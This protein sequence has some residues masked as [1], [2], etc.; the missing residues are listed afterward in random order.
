V[1]SLTGRAERAVLGAMISD[2]GLVGRLEYLQAGDFADWRHRAVFTAI[3]LAAGEPGMTADRWHSAITAHTSPQVPAQLINNLPGACPVVAHGVAYG[4]LVVE[5]SVH[6]QLAG[7]GR[8]LASRGEELAESAGRAIAAGA[9]DGP[10][11]AELASHLK[12]LGEAFTR[13]AAR[14]VTTSGQP[15]HVQ[16]EAPAPMPDD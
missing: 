13:H 2:P 16:Q 5:G 8:T 7:R 4:A 3:L 11:A 6:R 12:Q 14:I 9:S 1:E 15:G 10:Q